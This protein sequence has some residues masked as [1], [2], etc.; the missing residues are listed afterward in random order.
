M[1]TV[2]SWHWFSLPFFSLSLSLSLFRSLYFS[3][4]F[5][6]VQMFH[7]PKEWRKKQTT[8]LMLTYMYTTQTDLNR[9]LSTEKNWPECGPH[10]WEQWQCVEEL[11]AGCQQQSVPQGVPLSAGLPPAPAAVPPPPSTPAADPPVD[12][13]HPLT[14]TTSMSTGYKVCE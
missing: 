2:Y 10:T 9:V 4:F 12:I 13:S 8:G 11:C 3:L 14:S 5:V 1:W 6:C 7:D